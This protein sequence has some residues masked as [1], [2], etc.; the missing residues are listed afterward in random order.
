MIFSPMVSPSGDASVLVVRLLQELGPLLGLPLG[1]HDPRPQLGDR[2]AVGL[3]LREPGE[4]RLGGGDVLRRRAGRWRKRGS[5]RGSPSSPSAALAAWTRAFSGSP[6]RRGAGRPGREGRPGRG[7]RRAALRGS[8]SALRTSS[9]RG[10]WARTA[11]RTIRSSGTSLRLRL[12]ADQGHRLLPGRA[13]GLVRGEAQRELARRPD[14]RRVAAADQPERLLGVVPAAGLVVEGDRGAQHVRSPRASGCDGL[15][16]AL[17]GPAE[18]AD[19]AVALGEQQ[20]GPVGLDVLADLLD[21]LRRRGVMSL[22]LIWSIRSRSQG[23]DSVGFSV[24]HFAGR[25][26]GLLGLAQSAGRPRSPSCRVLR[27]C[28]SP[29]TACLASSSARSMSLDWIACIGRRLL[30]GVATAGYALARSCD[31]LV[32]LLGREQRHQRV[33]ARPAPP[34]RSRALW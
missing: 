3:D 27:P 26:L 25:G 5:R 28:G 31:L 7:V 30:D 11:D 23:V 14:V 15:L 8:R 34:P 20:L 21:G 22:A 1:G 17:G 33:R 4:L 32:P 10:P 24:T 16:E 19:G 9:G 12:G 13:V 2:Q 29:A 18:V 6:G